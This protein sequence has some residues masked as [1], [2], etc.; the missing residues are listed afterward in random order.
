CPIGALPS[1]VSSARRG[2]GVTN[3]ASSARVCPHGCSSRR[4]TSGRSGPTYLAPTRPCVQ[5]T[6]STP[7][8]IIVRIAA[9]STRRAPR[10]RRR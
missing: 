2:S 10:T 7:G 1:P 8:P 6:R 5:R 3:P 9:R 4:V